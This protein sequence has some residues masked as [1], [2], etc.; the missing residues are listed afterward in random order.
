MPILY[1]SIYDYYETDIREKKLYF[2]VY[3]E[4]GKDRLLACSS[5]ITGFVTP[6]DMDKAKVKENNSIKEKCAGEQYNNLQIRR[7]SSGFYFRDIKLF[8]EARR[9]FQKLHV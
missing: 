4:D 1:N 8:G 2:L 9:R 6:P 7:K 5:P 3:T